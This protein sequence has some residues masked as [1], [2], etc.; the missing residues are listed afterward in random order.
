MKKI[1]FCLLAFYT[2]VSIVIA[3]NTTNSPTSMFGLGELSTG[4]GGQYAGLVL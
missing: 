4:E 1:L 3:Q 2:P